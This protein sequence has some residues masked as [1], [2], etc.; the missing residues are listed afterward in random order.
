[1]CP[2]FYT[3][4]RMLFVHLFPIS[5]DSTWWAFH[6]SH[7]ATR[8]LCTDQGG[9]MT[10]LPFRDHV[11]SAGEVVFCPRYHSSHPSFPCS[12][13][14]GALSLWTRCLHQRLRFLNRLGPLWGSLVARTLF[15]HPEESVRHR[16]SGPR[17]YCTQKSLQCLNP[18]ASL[19]P[20]IL[21]LLNGVLNSM[22]FLRFRTT[23]GE[24]F[25]KEWGSRYK[26]GGKAATT[27]V[28]SLV[29]QACVH[30]YG[31]WFFPHVFVGLLCPLTKRLIRQWSCV[32]VYTD[33]PNLGVLVVWAVIYSIYL[34]HQLVDE[35]SGCREV[36]YRYETN[37]YCFTTVFTHTLAHAHPI[38]PYHCM[39][40]RQAHSLF[41]QTG[42]LTT[43]FTSHTFS[44]CSFWIQKLIENKIKST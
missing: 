19:K 1:M 11:L 43:P 34:C 12:L 10:P 29:R 32:S 5:I 36:N 16:H 30:F 8:C 22:N 14:L 23:P 7:S 37:S 31:S 2:V 3:S 42:P 6:H 18:G 26:Q 33:P 4:I 35:F 25:A 9:V 44:V 41:Y 24:T 40:R 27:K 21:Y 17:T 13:R 15:R 38:L 28:T 20:P 39:E